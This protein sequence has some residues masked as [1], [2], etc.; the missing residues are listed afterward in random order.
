MP[1]A[2]EKKTAMAGVWYALAVNCL[3][4]SSGLNAS[5]LRS[6]AGRRFEA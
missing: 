1:C 3:L 2:A 5:R 4:L 6:G